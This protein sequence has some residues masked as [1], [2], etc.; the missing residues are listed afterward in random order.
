MA[1]GSSVKVKNGQVFSN[2]RNSAILPH[3]LYLNEFSQ[4]L[5]VPITLHNSPFWELI[6]QIFLYGMVLFFTQCLVPLQSIHQAEMLGVS[7]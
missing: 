7:V 3:R 2:I 4:G 5:I 1:S 6:V